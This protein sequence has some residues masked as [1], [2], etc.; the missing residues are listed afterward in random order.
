MRTDHGH[1]YLL[2]KFKELCE[3]KCI[4]RQL[5]ILYASQQNGVAEKKS[6]TLLQIV[7]SMM[8][9]ANIPIS[10][11]GDALVIANCIL[12]CVPTKSVTST[13]YEL[14]IEKKT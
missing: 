11:W 2:E 13:P 10:Y 3:S 7:R 14:W 9:Q 5:I 4:K 6:R 12:N 1:K 8:A